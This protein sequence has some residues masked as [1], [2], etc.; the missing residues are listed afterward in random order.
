MLERV[1]T[2]NFC[3]F[4]NEY[5][6][7]THTLK[8]AGL[9]M[10]LLSLKIRFTWQAKLHSS[11]YCLWIKV[12]EAEIETCPGQ[13]RVTAINFFSL[14][15]S[16]MPPYI[17]LPEPLFMADVLWPSRQIIFQGAGSN[18]PLLH[19]EYPLVSELDKLEHSIQP[20]QTP[21]PS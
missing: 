13:Q 8:R 16:S 18:S 19:P 1:S 17:K 11:P 6:Y 7:Y 15:S 4:P 14:S 5:S 10:A 9:I 3:L 21:S 20:W 12:W 2:L